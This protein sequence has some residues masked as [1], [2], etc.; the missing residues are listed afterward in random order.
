MSLLKAFLYGLRLS[1]SLPQFL[2]LT[3]YQ[4]YSV[5]QSG[6]FHRLSCSCSHWSVPLAAI[7]SLLSEAVVQWGKISSNGSILLKLAQGYSIHSVQC[8][9]S[10]SLA[11]VLI[12]QTAQFS[13]TMSVLQPWHFNS[14]LVFSSQK[15]ANGS[16]GPD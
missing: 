2:Q 15:H 14:K 9:I 16:F 8:S 13:K 12:G 1:S 10:F 5:L 6:H 3:P 11:Q 7:V 4:V